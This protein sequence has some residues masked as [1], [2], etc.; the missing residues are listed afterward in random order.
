MNLT[1]RVNKLPN[2]KCKSE[3]VP[4]GPYSAANV[5]HFLT[6]LRMTSLIARLGERSVGE[7]GGGLRLS[8]PTDVGSTFLAVF[9][10]TKFCWMEHRADQAEIPSVH[11]SDVD[12]RQGRVAA[13][14]K[15]VF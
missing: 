9:I 15:S 7:V 3:L 11:H 6:C 13:V 1:Q 8:D 10:H 2:L 12:P 4:Q 14:T 5:P